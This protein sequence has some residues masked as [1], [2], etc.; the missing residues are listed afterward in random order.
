MPDPPD[1][2]AR[3]RRGLSLTGAISLVS[4]VCV[5]VLVS[6]P[7]LRDFAVLE[8]TRDART[9][10]AFLTKELAKYPEA[11]ADLRF[12]DLFEAR[13]LRHTLSDLELLAAGRLLRRH[14]Y[15]FTL[16]PWNAREAVAPDEEADDEAVRPI[17]AGAELPPPPLAVLAW[18]WEHTRTGTQL[19]LGT[20]RG[21][22]WVHDN[23]TLRWSGPRLEVKALDDMTGWR[24]D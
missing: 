23:Q 9:T 19:I 21:E 7:R 12:G 18:P 16:V 20:S 24:R 14:G 2:P 13:D 3:P 4:V 1:R 6:L 22:V 17:E 10:V 5:L 15:L 11:S 8:N